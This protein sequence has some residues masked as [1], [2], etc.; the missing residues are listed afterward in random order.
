LRVVKESKVGILL[1][2]ATDFLEP[3]RIKDVVVI[4]ENDDGASGGS[5]AIGNH[6]AQPIFPR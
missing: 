1:E 2:S 6:R 5:N 3:T 4:K